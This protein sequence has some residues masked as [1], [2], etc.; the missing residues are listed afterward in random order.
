M[1]R[2]LAAGGVVAVALVVGA[3]SGASVPGG[4]RTAP[5]PA[6]RKAPVAAAAHHGPPPVLRHTAFRVPGVGSRGIEIAALNAVVE[7][8]CRGCHNDKN[9]RGNVSLEGFAIDSAPNDVE[10][11]EKMIRKLRT[12]M[13]PPPTSRRPGG[14]TL[15][16]L[17]ETLEQTIDAAS[18]PMAGVRT[19]QRLNRPEYEAAVRDLLGVTV[20]AADYLPLDTKSANFDN[21][22]DVQMLS[23]TLLEA[24]LNAA[25]SV[26]RMALGDKSAPPIP[27]TYRIS[28]FVSQ[29]PWDHVDG[30][31]FGTRGGIVETHTFPADGKYVFRVNV[32]GGIGTKFEDIDISVD[33][34]QVALLKYDKGVEPTF[35]S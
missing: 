20:D 12:A 7:R 22:A 13:M 8:Y 19:F 2:A 31:P 6:A 32:G 25:A 30:A 14:D 5:A 29:H 33:G 27:V 9:M 28:P 4:T 15:L 34:Q 3:A 17:V 35:A 11:A 23:P 16:A 1:N 18:K 21:V 26:T 10:V 24:Y